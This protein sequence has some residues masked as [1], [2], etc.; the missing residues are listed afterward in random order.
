MVTCAIIG[1]PSFPLSGLGAMYHRA[2]PHTLIASVWIA[3]LVT[4]RMRMS[5]S[6]P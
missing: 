1:T 4:D 3:P 5:A 2:R 6:E